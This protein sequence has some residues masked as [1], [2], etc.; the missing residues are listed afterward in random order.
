MIAKDG[1]SSQGLIAQYY[2]GTL[3]AQQGDN[4]TAKTYLTKVAGS[5]S[6]CSPLAKIAL[7]QLYAGEGKTSEARNLL[8]SIVNKP[9]AL[10]S[11]DQADILIARLDESADPKAAKALL[12]SL[13]TPDQRP[14]VSR[15]VS[16]MEATLS[17]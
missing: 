8:Q 15:A 10:V 14:A 6:Q 17:K 16:E 12:Q 11:K 7:A 4:K 3:K 9:S 2:L 13:K 5:N 1:D